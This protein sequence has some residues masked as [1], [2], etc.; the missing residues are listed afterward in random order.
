VRRIKEVTVLFAIVLVLSGDGCNEPTP[1]DN[2]E[3]VWY[4]YEPPTS[5]DWLGLDYFNKSNVWVAGVRDN[6]TGMAL[7]FDGV[8]LK[9]HTPPVG[10]GELR[11]CCVQAVNNVWFVG[12][13]SSIYRYDG[14]LFQVW[15]VPVGELN[16]VDTGSAGFGFAV[17]DGGTILEFNGYEW[18]QTESPTEVDLN[19]VEFVS[20]NEAW[21]VGDEGVVLHY[22]GG[23]WTV[24]APFAQTD[25]YDTSFVSTDDG[26]FVGSSGAVY[27]YDGSSWTRYEVPNPD[28][29]FYCAAFPVSGKG[30]I[31]GDITTLLVFDG[32]T[33]TRES[34]LPTGPWELRALTAPTADEAWAVGPGIILF[35]R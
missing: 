6:G 12:A 18:A 17:G 20:A 28:V 33:F 19:S 4:F 27:H 29:N 21:A 11:D 31:G 8:S 24:V 30:W 26:W 25:L 10:T 1:P 16:G 32:E 34:N 7:L 13:D 23:A 22:A 14:E 2:D 5:G 9:T 35:Y 15:N 3:P